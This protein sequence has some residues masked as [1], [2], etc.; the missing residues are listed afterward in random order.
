MN[1]GNLIEPLLFNRNENPAATLVDGG[2]SK[3]ATGAPNRFA[4]I[5][6]LRGI[7]ALGIVVFHLWWYEPAP[8]PV[9]GTEPTSADEAF[10]KIRASVQI[11]LVISGFV[12]AYTLRRTWVTPTEMYWF[13]GRRLVRLV[14]CYW[15]TIATV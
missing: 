3:P 9:F 7:A 6:G 5:D 15:V 2:S 11:L 1:T 4:Y 10:R 8:F 14:P 13:I 12:I